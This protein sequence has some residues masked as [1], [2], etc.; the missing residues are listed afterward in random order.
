MKEIHDFI[1]LKIVELL[2]F[3]ENLGQAYD[4]MN[5]SPF[6]NGLFPRDI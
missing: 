3:A 6:S 2:E 4:A 1:G 5:P